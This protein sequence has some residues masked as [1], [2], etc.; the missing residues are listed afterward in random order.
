MIRFDLWLLGT[1]SATYLLSPRP[2]GLNIGAYALIFLEVV[3]GFL[4]QNHG[5]EAPGPYR[6]G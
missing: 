1:F 6:R 4:V 5:S 2:E 3:L